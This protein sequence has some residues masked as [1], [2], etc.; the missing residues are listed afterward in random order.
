MQQAKSV[1]YKL[2]PQLLKNLDNLEEFVTENGCHIYNFLENSTR[3]ALPPL[4]VKAIEDVAKK[5]IPEAEG[6]QQL[7]KKSSCRILDTS[8]EEDEEIITALVTSEKK[9]VKFSSALT[10]VKGVVK[11]FFS[12]HSL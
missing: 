12:V 1:Q 8:S 4:V 6:N 9:K 7:K 2:M 11:N 10:E 5:V 3:I